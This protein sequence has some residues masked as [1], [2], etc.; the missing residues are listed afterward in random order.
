MSDISYTWK[1]SERLSILAEVKVSVKRAHKWCF[2]VPNADKH[3]RKLMFGCVKFV[4]ACVRLKL[5]LP[6]QELHQQCFTVI[7]LKC[8]W[9]KQFS[10]IY[11]SLI[12]SLLLIK[13]GFKYRGKQKY[14]KSKVHFG[15]L[16]FLFKESSCDSF[17]KPSPTCWC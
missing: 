6:V 13:K 16:F 17:Q 12:F 3:V 5:W 11:I 15:N 9:H 2:E 4:S 8:N 7:P 1:R 14:R 10:H